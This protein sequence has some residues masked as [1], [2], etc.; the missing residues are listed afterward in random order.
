MTFGRNEY[1]RT[2]GRTLHIIKGQA[3]AVE[4]Y[5]G[6][7]SICDATFEHLETTRELEV[8]KCSLQYIRI[9]STLLSLIPPFIEGQSQGSILVLPQQCS[10]LQ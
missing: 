5:M 3:V 2:G 6:G 10:V 7:S 9:V 4:D 1:T 8:S